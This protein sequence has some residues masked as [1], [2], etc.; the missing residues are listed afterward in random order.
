MYPMIRLDFGFQCDSPLDILTD[1]FEKQPKKSRTSILLPKPVYLWRIT[2]SKSYCT[3]LEE[4]FDEL[5]S[6]IGPKLEAL[7]QLLKDP[8]LRERLLVAFDAIVVMEIDERPVLCL[9]EERIALLASLNA[10][11]SV[12]IY[13]P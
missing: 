6:M 8:D 2:T 9:S 10:Q 12:V 1:L 4:K 13:S 11:F 3:D 7:V 5:I